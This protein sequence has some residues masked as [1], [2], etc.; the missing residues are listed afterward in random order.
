MPIF[1]QPSKGRRD[2]INDPLVEGK[3]NSSQDVHTSKFNRSPVKGTQS[4]GVLN[5]GRTGLG[6]T[7]FDSDITLGN[8]ANLQK[9][10]A[11]RQPWYDQ[12][13][14]FLA[15]AV[16]GEI[17]GGTIEGLGYLG[18]IE[19]LVN[20]AKG[21]EEEWGNFIS[22]IGKGLRETTQEGMPI[23]QAN[24]GEFDP[25]DSGWWFGNGVSIASTLSMMIPSMA[26]TKGLSMA[27]K[28]LSKGLGLINKSADI[29]AKM[30]SQAKW[31]ATG[32]SQAI[33]SRHIENM[34]EASG[35]F[36][37]K[38]EGYIQNGMNPEQAKELAAE[39]A[40]INYRAGYAMLL[41]DIPQYLAIGKVFNPITGRM[42]SK[43]G[44]M[45]EAGKKPGFVKKAGTKLAAWVSLMV[46]ISYSV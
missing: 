6:E 25:S 3:H 21:S 35:T 16:V 8:L 15:Q 26:A 33:A 45:A 40:S 27:G 28:G 36:D 19:G 17:I 7:K 1:T 38:R 5:V 43:L 39:A 12:A 18:D 11:A 4:M 29:A 30:G 31:A 34:M 13:G 32:V 44:A 14:N 10:R 46:S 20:I 2:P 42:Q 37:E 24:P 41:M 23:Y 22:D 9:I